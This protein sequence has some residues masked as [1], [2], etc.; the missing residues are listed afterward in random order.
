MDH[1]GSGAGRDQPHL[2]A[3]GGALHVVCARLRP[4]GEFSQGR[5]PVFRCGNRGSGGAHL[6]R[7][8]GSAVVAS[9]FQRFVRTQKRKPGMPGF[10]A[11]GSRGSQPPAYLGRIT[12]STTWITPLLVNTSAI[13]MLLVRRF[14]SVITRLAFTVKVCPWTVA[15]AELIGTS[16]LSTRAGTTWKV[17]TVVSSAVSASR[18]SLVTPSSASSAAKAALVGANT[19]NGPAPCKVVAKPAATTASTRMLKSGSAEAVATMSLLACSRTRSTKCTTPLLAWMSVAVMVETLLR[20]SVIFRPLADSI[21]KK[22]PDTG[23]MALPRGT[24]ARGTLLPST[25]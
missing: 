3:A 5:R 13:V 16:A 20:P 22:P 25:W 21:L 15:M 4:G 1:P 14:W 9:P 18:A 6:F 12:L 23:V 7:R 8:A 17:S 19:V 2:A 24:S 10:L 11:W